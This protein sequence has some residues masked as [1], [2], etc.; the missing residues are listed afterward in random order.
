[1]DEYNMLARGVIK[2]TMM[3]LEHLN[4]P[5]PYEELEFVKKQLYCILDSQF[6]G[7]LYVKKH[8]NSVM[9]QSNN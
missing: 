6:K 3:V 2:N 5:I 9:L 7:K 4:T 1:M 8:S